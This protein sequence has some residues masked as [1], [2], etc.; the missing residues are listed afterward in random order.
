MRFRK[1]TAELWTILSI[2]TRTSQRH[3]VL[4]ASCS[5][6]SISDRNVNSHS[7]NPQFNVSVNTK[8]HSTFPL[9]PTLSL[10]VNTCDMCPL[11]QQN[12]YLVTL[13]GPEMNFNT[14]VDPVNG[15]RERVPGSNKKGWWTLPENIYLSQMSCTVSWMTTQ[16]KCNTHYGNEKYAGNLSRKPWL[17]KVFGRPEIRWE[18]YIMLNLRRTESEGKN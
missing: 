11:P 17:G 16:R 8:S 4:C 10:Y 14:S 1:S 18:D 7:C 5:I 15:N 9:S 12:Q 13:A 3:A 6:K 2:N